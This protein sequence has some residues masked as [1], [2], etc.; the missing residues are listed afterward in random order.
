M[1]AN[2]WW[3]QVKEAAIAA[4]ARAQEQDAAQEAREAAAPPLEARLQR[5]VRAHDRYGASD[6][7]HLV[8]YSDSRVLEGLLLVQ[9]EMNQIKAVQAVLLRAFVLEFL[10]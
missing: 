2:P 7:L 4:L 9:L 6:L 10:F 1:D 3:R 5:E 8:H